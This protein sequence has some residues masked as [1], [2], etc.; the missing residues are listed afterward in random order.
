M[1]KK[2]IMVVEDE[3]ITAMRIQS[4]LEDMGYA[5]TSTVFTGE[6]AIKRTAEDRPDLVLMD[7]ILGGKMDGI[8]TA[9]QIRSR[10][11]IPVIYLTAH[12]NKKMQERV[13]KTEP[14]GF[15]VKPFDE[16]ELQIVVDIALYKHEMDR[17]LRESEMKYRTLFE[18]ATD[19]IYLIDPETQHIIDCN[20]SAEKITGYTIK[21]LRSMNIE[22]LHHKR[23]HGIVSK[24][25][26]KVSE[27]GLLSGIS[28]VNHLRKD[29]KLVPVEINATT[30]K[31]QG[32]KYCLCISRDITK[33]KKAEDELRESEERFH[34]L[35][36]QASDSIVIF[37]AGTV[38]LTQFNRK[39]CEN[40]GYTR[41]E[42]KNLKLSDIEAAE[43]PDSISNHLEKII[44]EGRDTF[45]TKY[46]TKNG[47][48]R[49]VLVNAAVIHIRG[50]DYI[51]STWIDITGRKMMEDQLRE[52]AITDDL[53]G[54]LNR[55]GFFAFSGQQCKL[56]DR[57]KKPMSLLYLDIDGLKTI[58][59]ELG[60]K[61][62]DNALIDAA[63]ILK[64]SFRKSDIIGRIG[65]D[66]FAVL[67]TEPSESDIENV[68]VAHLRKKLKEF[69]IQGGRNYELLLSMGIAHY[70]PDRPCSIDEILIRADDLM[71]EDKR[72]YHRLIQKK[73]P[74]IKTGAERREYK[75]FGIADN[76]RAEIDIIGKVMIKDISIGGI[77]LKTLQSMHNESAC[78]I[79]MFT[80]GNKVLISS[81][82]VVWSAL[83]GKETA[84]ENNLS[85][86][87]SGLKFTG[88]KDS[89]KSSIEKFITDL[90]I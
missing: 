64:R 57:N 88:M 32:K 35:F 25:F 34:S 87:E 70:D 24:I 9:G 2:R 52:A 62:G 38:R 43:F 27:K 81:G 39:A 89:L 47:R 82:I 68:V 16:R 55:R 50:K 76:C 23:E 1:T 36:E 5:V 63:D 26:E 42:F 71:Y 48:I 80:P 31:L 74:L 6:E 90:S 56:A 54:L 83:K 61:A 69:N 17:R 53:T 15:I 75:R 18:N 77:C 44:K 86:Y 66:E 59:D 12:S 49:D 58:N 3:G 20:Q 14:F 65:G 72:H 67:L 79:R 11:D 22:E 73:G 30:I 13:K 85:M 19:A 21:Q 46:R 84:E 8:E 78:E 7:I 37:D 4:S 10:F 51:Q 40:L 28:G 41:A 60:H 45:E 29:G 33:R